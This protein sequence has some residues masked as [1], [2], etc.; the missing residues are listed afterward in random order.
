VCHAVARRAA[1]LSAAAVA[2][3]LQKINRLEDATVAVDGNILYMLPIFI[4]L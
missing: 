1:R 2:A 4:T 3:V